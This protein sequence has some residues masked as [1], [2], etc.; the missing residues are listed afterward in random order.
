MTEEKEQL[1]IWVIYKHPSDYPNKYVARKWTKPTDSKKRTLLPTEIKLIADSIEE[2]R[3]KLPKF[4][5]RF[6][7][8][9]SDDPCIV[10]TWM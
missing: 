8:D 3:S 9:I 7:R 10:E 6:E 1:I 4:L 2:I 5:T